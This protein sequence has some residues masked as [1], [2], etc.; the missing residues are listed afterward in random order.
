MRN[1][2][3]GLIIGIVAGI[4]LGTT[5][6]APR[7]AQNVKEEIG[8]TAEPA[9]GDD[10]ADA[11]DSSDEQNEQAATVERL[12]MLSAHSADLVGY[13]TLA[14]RLE[15]TIWRISDGTFDLRFHAPGSLVSENDA[16]NALTSGSI[17][18]Y[19][20]EA[21]TLTALDPGFQLFAGLPFGASVA[22]YTGWMQNGDGLKLLQDLLSDN[23]LAGLPCGIIPH[24]GGGWFM[25]P[26]KTV[27]DLKDMRVRASGIAAALFRRLGADVVDFSFAETMIAMESGLLGGAQLS[28]PHVDLALGA[29]R[30]GR[31]YYVPGWRTPARVF[32]LLMAKEKWDGLSEVS[33]SRIST[34]CADN[35][36]HSISEGE[37]LQFNALKEIAK[38][39]ADVQAWPGEIVDAMRMAWNTE[40]TEQQKQHRSY[41]KV[42]RSYQNFIKGQSIWEELVRP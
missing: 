25:K 26:L 3:I 23:D 9:D 34:A 15:K 36:S 17:D 16:L 2:V 33:K 12:R 7:L 13:G 35:V 27:E 5:V 14:K 6:I 11:T 30:E 19:F 31:V 4:V 22:A 28:A 10:A 40:A 41:A 29:A 42:L 39:G 8:L 18:A 37:A 32:V 21:S 38:Q 24:A 20:S 1:A